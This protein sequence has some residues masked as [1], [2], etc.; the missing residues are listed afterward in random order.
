VIGFGIKK[1]LTVIFLLFQIRN[2][3]RD[4]ETI[5]K[6]VAQLAIEGAALL[7]QPKELQDILEQIDIIFDIAGTSL[8]GSFLL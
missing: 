8:V 1:L 4:L 6:S 5:M 2:F 7:S 3:S